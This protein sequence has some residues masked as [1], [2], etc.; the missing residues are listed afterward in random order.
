M[1][2]Q[3]EILKFRG[4]PIVLISDLRIPLTEKNSDLYYYD[5]RHAD[6]DFSCPATIEKLVRVNHQGTIASTEPLLKQGEN[7]IDLTQEESYQLGYY[8]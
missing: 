7:S 2:T 3:T 8:I 4:T 1:T 5:I 6:D